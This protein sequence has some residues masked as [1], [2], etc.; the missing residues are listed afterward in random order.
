MVAVAADLGDAGQPPAHPTINILNND[1]AA[2]YV[3]TIKTDSKDV[4]KFGS[5]LLNILQEL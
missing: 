4:Q 5:I 2:I 1:A 3:Q